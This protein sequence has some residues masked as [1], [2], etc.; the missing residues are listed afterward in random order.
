V[1]CYKQSGFGREMAMET[2]HL[3]TEQ[4][5]VLIHT[6]EKPVNPFGV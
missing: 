2:L 4:K 6:A 5:T 3:Y 1:A